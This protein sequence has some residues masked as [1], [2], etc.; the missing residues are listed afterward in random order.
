MLNFFK[1]VSDAFQC[2]RYALYIRFLFW[3]P[4]WWHKKTASTNFMRFRWWRW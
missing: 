4:Y 2:I 3:R 1:A